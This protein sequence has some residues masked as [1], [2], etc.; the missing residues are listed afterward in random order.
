MVSRRRLWWPLVLA[1]VAL[2][3][4]GLMLFRQ[5]GLWELGIIL[6]PVA[7]VFV[8]ES[9]RYVAGQFKKGYRRRPPSG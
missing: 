9:M 5:I 7:L 6:G 1:V 4:C 8:I 2:I 3:A